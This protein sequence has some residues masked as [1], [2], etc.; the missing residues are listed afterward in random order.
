MTQGPPKA[1]GFGIHLPNVPTGRR[2]PLRVPGALQHLQQRPHRAPGKHRQRQQESFDIARFTRSHFIVVRII[3]T[4]EG[5]RG[6]EKIE[7]PHPADITFGVASRPLATRRI[8]SAR[9]I[10]SGTSPRTFKGKDQ[11]MR[12]F[13]EPEMVRFSNRFIPPEIRIVRIMENY[14]RPRAAQPP[15]EKSF[16][17][18]LQKNRVR[19]GH[20]APLES[21]SLSHQN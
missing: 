8:R 4:I 5:L 6:V 3:R 16:C 21:S 10:P 2:S 1:P 18:G 9:C 13:T 12:P 14:R 11:G 20:S 19:G 15:S 7:R 17:P